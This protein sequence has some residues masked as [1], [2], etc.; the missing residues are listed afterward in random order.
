[1]RIN[2]FWL[3]IFLVIQSSLSSITIYGQNPILYNWHTE[4]NGSIN[5]QKVDGAGNSYITG[6]SYYNTLSV[7]GFK[8]VGRPFE[9]SSVGAFV[10]KIN[11]NGYV[12]WGVNFEYGTGSDYGSKI[13]IDEH[14]NVYLYGVYFGDSLKIG[15]NVLYKTL[16]NSGNIFITKL[17]SNGNVLYVKTLDVIPCSGCSVVVPW[18]RPTDMV[19]DQNGD[20]LFSANYQSGRTI[21]F[22]PDTIVS[23]TNSNQIHSNNF[24]AKLS[25]NG[26]PIWMKQIVSTSTNGTINPSNIAISNDN[27]IFISGIFNGNVTI[28]G[29]SSS[30]TINSQGG[31]DTFILKLSSNGNPSVIRSIGGNGNMDY[32]RNLKFTNNGRLYLVMVSNSTSLQVSSQTLNINQMSNVYGQGF[33][34]LL[35]Q[36]TDNLDLL[37]HKNFGGNG[38]EHIEALET[39]NDNSILIG[40]S[41]SSDSLFYGSSIIASQNASSNTSGCFFEVDSNGNLLQSYLS[42]SN[43]WHIIRQINCVDSQFYFRLDTYSSDTINFLGTPLWSRSYG[44]MENSFVVKG[45]YSNPICVNP[46]NLNI[47]TNG[48]QCRGFESR[49]FIDPN[50]LSPNLKIKWEKLDNG[51]WSIIDTLY[52]SINVMLLND[53]SV[54]RVTTKCDSSTPTFSIVSIVSIDCSDPCLN[55]YKNADYTIT[56][57]VNWPYGYSNVGAFLTKGR[58]K[59]DQHEDI[60]VAAPGFSYPDTTQNGLLYGD[61]FHG[62]VMIGY[63]EN[64]IFKVDTIKPNLWDFGYDVAGGIDFNGD[65]FDDLLI[66]TQSSGLLYLGSNTGL[67]ITPSSTING[68]PWNIQNIAGKTVW[69]VKD[70]NGDGFDEFLIRKGASLF[71]Y[72]GNTQGVFNDLTA[73]NLGVQTNSFE[74]L[75]YNK[76]GFIDVITN[77]HILLRNG[78]SFDTIPKT[79]IYN[80]QVN[81][82]NGTYGD[83]NGDG[84]IDILHNNFIYISDSSGYFTQGSSSLGG[85]KATL[86]Y[87]INMD[88][89]NELFELIQDFS[90]SSGFSALVYH[91]VDSNF[92]NT[93]TLQLGYGS[94]YGGNS[95]GQGMYFGP[96][97]DLNGDSILDYVLSHELG[98]GYINGHAK[99]WLGKTRNYQYQNDTIRTYSQLQSFNLAYGI[100]DTLHLDTVA[101]LYRCDTIKRTMIDLNSNVKG[102]ISYASQLPVPMQGVIV[103]L[104]KSNQVVYQTVSDQ[105]GLFDFGLI[106]NNQYTVDFKSFL[107]RRGVNAA[108]A[109]MAMRHYTG[110]LPL[111]GIKLKAA[112]VNGR[113]IVNGQEALKILQR[114]VDLNLP[115]VAG[116]W[117]FDTLTHTTNILDS[118]T[119]ISNRMLCYG[120]VNA[121]Y[122]PSPPSRLASDPLMRLGRLDVNPLSDLWEW[123]IYLV[124]SQSIGSMTLE[125]VLPDNLIVEDVVITA[126][127]SKGGTNGDPGYSAFK[128]EGN[129]LKVSWFGIDDLLPL[130]GEEMIR[131][132]VR[133]DAQGTLKIVSTSEI[134]DGMGQAY[135]TF[136]LAAPVRGVDCNVTLFP[137]PSNGITSLA[138]T[139]PSSGTLSY[140]VVDAFGRLISSK[141]EKVLNSCFK[142]IVLES[143]QWMPGSYLIKV[144]WEGLTTSDDRLLRFIKLSR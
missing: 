83:V 12:Q 20:V 78:A 122:F 54:F 132:R 5:D 134:T 62:A 34:A 11:K 97:L 18:M 111:S 25:S 117:V 55:Y 43:G 3:R 106:R 94:T 131:L 4:M 39:V 123:P 89:K 126:A 125:F 82:V 58:Y 87:D 103:E 135:S 86:Q 2:L 42:N 107:P 48:Q 136:S 116:D 24:V 16:N 65:G 40:G 45:S 137:N 57:T 119:N 138:L 26:S 44:G 14:K 66:T 120:D 99:I 1:M 38:D 68:L 15:N 72:Y 140:T 19:F 46:P 70:L 13:L 77:R 112:N 80:G 127:R 71:I 115:F 32:V 10:F 35:F 130:D 118:I 33:D 81:Y 69:P 79:F 129:L 29:L 59:G 7:G 49:I 141:E 100:N 92:V 21:I 52:S 22:G 91:F 53:T 63:F 139:L 36:F 102:Q 144:R 90:I 104:K 60:V 76:D 9:I 73:I 31:W 67:A 85:F 6:Q 84:Y 143:N 30:N 51:V 50:S 128:Q 121:S 113:G 37:W 98:G 41:S 133:G 110:T 105:S 75:D 61:R 93:D 47:T 124:K 28:N 27:S 8:L 64:D 96:K 74:D 23:T 142:E 95:F 17:D 108:D 114:T 109:L 101:G 88:G 56:S